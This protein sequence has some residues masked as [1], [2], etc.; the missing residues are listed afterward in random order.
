MVDAAQDSI[1][2]RV[3]EEMK[4]SKYPPADK[5]HRTEI[6]GWLVVYQMELA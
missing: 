4:Q 3:V 6:A 2:L 1:S 5:I